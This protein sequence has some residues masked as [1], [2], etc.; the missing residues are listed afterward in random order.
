MVE[1]ALR[2]N[3]TF[4]QE[5][6]VFCGDA[7]E[8][9]PVCAEAS[10][11]GEPVGTVCPECLSAGATIEARIRAHAARLRDQAGWLEAVAAGPFTMPT[12]ARYEAEAGEWMP[13]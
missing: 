7:F 8:L 13:A 3:G 10:V 4:M 11:G 1:V 6:C 2:P 5:G 9:G 12:R